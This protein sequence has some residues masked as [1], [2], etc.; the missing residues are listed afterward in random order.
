MHD[1]DTTRVSDYDKFAPYVEPG[2]KLHNSINV[3]FERARKHQDAVR[4]A[5][6][7]YSFGAGPAE[8]LKDQLTVGIRAQLGRCEQCIHLYYRLKKRLLQEM[9]S[10][11]AEEEV[12]EFQRIIDSLD[13]EH[14]QQNLHNVQ[15]ILE[16]LPADQRLLRQLPP[17]S[18]FA[19]LEALV[20]EASVKNSDFLAS[21]F[22]I[23]W[24]LCQTNEPFPLGEHTPALG[25][26]IFS[27]VEARS[28]WALNL[29][30]STQTLPLITP[31]IFNWAFRQAIDCAVQAIQNTH[32]GDADYQLRFWKGI[33]AVASRLTKDALTHHLLALEGN[34]IGMGLQLVNSNSPY[35][36][37]ILRCFDKLITIS[38]TDFWHAA[39]SFPPHMIVETILRAP[40]IKS[41]L[42]NAK[43]ETADTSIREATAW[44]WPFMASLKPANQSQVCGAITK[45]FLD[46]YQNKEYSE[47][48]RSVLLREGLEIMAETLNAVIPAA[49]DSGTGSIVVS[50]TLDIVMT[51]KDLIFNFASL[52]QS[53]GSGGQIA[54]AAVLVLR[55]AYGLDCKRLLNAQRLLQAKTDETHNDT[56]IQNSFW[57]HGFSKLRRNPSALLPPILASFTDASGLEEIVPSKTETD[58]AARNRI[59]QHNAVVGEFARIQSEVYLF[60]SEL[61]ESQV[62]RLFTDLKIAAPIIM[63]LFSSIEVI[64]SSAVQVMKN[65]T[66]ES[67]RP[68]AFGQII[69]LSYNTS[70]KGAM[71]AVRT[72][73][74]EGNLASFSRLFK[75]SS[76]ILEALFSFE[77]GFLRGKMLTPAEKEILTS[78]WKAMWTALRT[79]FDKTMEWDYKCSKDELRE[80]ARDAIQFAEKLFDH[81]Y[82]FT[83]SLEIE[84]TNKED[85]KWSHKEVM[86]RILEAPSLAMDVMVSWL[87]LSD[88]FLLTTMT[89]LVCKVFYQLRGQDL[90]IRE[91]SQTFVRKIAILG[92]I[93]SK[94]TRQQKAELSQALSGNEVVQIDDEPSPLSYPSSSSTTR[95]ST[96]V[97][98]VRPKLKQQQTIDLTSWGIKPTTKTEISLLGDDDDDEFGDVDDAELA[99]ALA[100]SEQDTKK[101]G[102]K[103]IVPLVPARTKLPTLPKVRS[104]REQVVEKRLQKAAQDRL[105]SQASG[106][107]LKKRRQ[108]AEE[109]RARDIAIAKRLKNKDSINPLSSGAGS[110]LKGLSGL[111]GIE[112]GPKPSGLL[113]G[114]DSDSSDSDSDDSVDKVM[115]LAGKPTKKSKAVEEIEASK[116]AMIMKQQMPT[117]KKKEAFSKHDVRARLVPDLRPLHEA[118][119]GWSFFHEGDFPPNATKDDYSLVSNVFSSPQAYVSTFSQLHL[120]EAWQGLLKDKEELNI[121]V[122]ELKILS[123]A[124]VDSFVEISSSMAQVDG[125]QLRLSESDIILISK[126]S[127]PTKNSKEPNCLA[128]INRIKRSKGNMEITYHVRHNG[129]L[130][131]S[132]NPGIV[133]H[134]VKVTSIVPLER[135]FTALLGLKYYDLR[136]EIC[137]AS[138]SPLLN[139]ADKHLETINKV[140]QLNKGQAKAV[141]SAVDN[142]CFTLIQGPPGSGKT[143]TI[144]AIVGALLTDT[145]GSKGTSISRPAHDINNGPPP[146]AKKL[147]VCAPSNAAVDE[148]VMR[149]KKGVKTLKNEFKML[150][151]VRI[152]KS[153]AI[154]KDVMDV[155][156]DYLVDQKLNI[157][158]RANTGDEI[159]KFVAEHSAKTG[160]INGLRDTLE[161]LRTEGRSS[162]DLE[163]QLTA[164]IK[165]RKFISDKLD[166]LRDGSG[167][168]IRNQEIHRKQVQQT[169]LS[170]ANVIC[171][172]L[173]GSGHD[174]FRNLPIEF[175]TV[176]IDE[177]AQSVELSALIPLK[178][179]CMKCILVGDPKQLP[180]TVLSREAARRQ[181]EQSLFVRMQQNFPDR[182]HLLDTQYRMHPDISQFPSQAFYDS[183]L[184]DGPG[185]AKERARPW[186][187]AEF[188]GPYHFF[189][190]EGQQRSAST[191]HSMMN[192]AEVNIALQ[193]YERLVRNFPRLNLKS[194][195]GIIT[196]YKAQL[197]KLRE[198]FAAKYG[199]QIFENIEFNSTDA[200]QGR[201]SEIIIFSCVRA[202]SKGI[203]FVGDVRRMNVGLT[204]AKASLWI[205]GNSKALGQNEFWGG[206]IKDA[207]ARLCY[208]DGHLSSKLKKAIR[209]PGGT[210]TAAQHQAGPGSD[211]NDTDVNM[212]DAPPSFVPPKT[213]QGRVFRKKQSDLPSE[214]SDVMMLDSDDAP[215]FVP[216]GGSNGLN[217]ALAC[218]FCGSMEHASSSC[219]NSEAKDMTGYKCYR[220]NST[221]HLSHNCGASLCTKCGAF[222]HLS[223][224][225]MSEKHLS[226]VEQRQLIHRENTRKQGISKAAEKRL[227]EREPKIPV[228]RTAADPQ[229]PG[230]CAGNARWGSLEKLDNQ[231]HQNGPKVLA[232]NAPHNAP[233]GPSAGQRNVHA[234][235]NRKRGPSPQQEQQ[236]KRSRHPTP[237][238]DSRPASGR[239]TPDSGAASDRMDIEKAESRTTGGV[240]RGSVGGKV[241]RRKV[242]DDPF[243]AA[244]RRRR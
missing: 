61:A 52:T 73:R 136:D 200:F 86:T 213:G 98:L 115:A 150:S 133:L 117:K 146:P 108:E 66:S 166:K 107:F 104:I 89:R 20:C 198:S 140:Y 18:L 43:D 38:P 206:L 48:V 125:K 5:L 102:S 36:V 142:D 144:V 209:Y 164:E 195:I 116:K 239:N 40:A 85:K 157:G 238:V 49:T 130:A 217:K 93:K 227:E 10:H 223:M 201:E 216:G 207:R 235:P 75:T 232:G 76:D 81:H 59:K 233:K 70:L 168:D 99:Q 28:T 132:L 63:S 91:N 163:I 169:I 182:V 80:F 25:Y 231:S 237:N 118:I 204:R 212:D 29:L 100:A 214:S 47:A 139:Y 225:C 241:I 88:E 128:R 19:I 84:D 154:N 106:D 103:K 203:G 152:G 230:N 51:Y 90:E 221:S 12:S 53:A 175:E 191:G 9:L 3:K 105:K 62:A 148:L 1:Q 156:L 218:G 158:K 30:Q 16:R 196:P 60:V 155:T 2:E 220:C 183:R 179:G 153:D 137:A 44:L 87:R 171:A 78:F 211:R 58:Q 82:D 64:F 55:K 174:M 240:P 186:H 113:V 172:T 50:Q 68:E 170:E 69:H 35:V 141:K 54:K 236:S 187:I 57:D 92:T 134:A 27:D 197:H 110:A 162:Q 178:Y 33:N 79:A 95:S 242:N 72:T 15:K 147:L 189:D 114:S 7:V 37:D 101:E 135:E 39:Q 56:T 184:I 173:S 74:E 41:H 205:L 149:F 210:T 194:K 185:L 202:S 4:E 119:L 97:S 180:P 199:E 167:A 45:A 143:K 190:V 226:K 208:T 181:Y 23:P 14:I 127:A 22:D 188:L 21:C 243:A 26:F 8:S 192:M 77:F 24:R 65:A 151:V 46:I 219:T 224:A 129:P 177:A 83:S 159:A 121:K 229:M 112:H 176:V 6:L 11:Y 124:T 131:G 32:W 160:I 120:L 161:S 228:V 123:R 145:F 34:V 234:L 222:G 13:L 67:S 109:K 138:P 244:Q 42:E 17:E 193:L 31:D 165:S 94:L 96:P 126:G 71:L 122:Y 111:Q 215:A